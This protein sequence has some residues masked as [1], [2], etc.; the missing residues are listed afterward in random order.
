MYFYIQKIYL[1]NETVENAQ[2]SDKIQAFR[3]MEKAKKLFGIHP[4]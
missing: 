1:R 4:A 2:Y 3:N